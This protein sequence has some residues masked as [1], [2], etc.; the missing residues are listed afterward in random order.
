MYTIIG[1]D[2]KAYGPVSVPQLKQWIAEGRATLDTQAK[3][4]GSEQWQSLRSYPEFAAEAALPPPVQPAGGGV[5]GIGLPMMG[6]PGSRVGAPPEPESVEFTGEWKEYF[7]I[8]IV[9]V[10]LT[11][12]TLGI[13]AAWAKVRKKRYFY[14]NT[15]VFGHTFEYLA[16]PLKIFYGNMIVGGIFLLLNLSVTMPIVYFFLALIFA[17]AVPW[18]IVRGLI[19][20]A[21]NSA[22][23]GLRFN[24]TGTY[25]G[26]FAVYI[27][28]PL[29]VGFTLGLIIPLIEKKKKEFVMNHHT[30]GTTPFGFS[31]M[32]GEIYK[33]FGISFLFFLPLLVAY[34]N[35]TIQL[36]TMRQ[37]G[38][39]FP[40][41]TSI[42]F[43]LG[44]GLIA[45]FGTFYFRAKMFNYVW[46]NTELANNQF[47]ATMEPLKLCGIHL[48]NAVVTL[49]TFGLAHPWA[50]IRV[51]RY[52][53][54]C[55]QI[56]PAGNVDSFVASAQPA[57]GA[58]GDSAGDFFD[59]DIGFG[60]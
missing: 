12:V 43:L 8:W 27:G 37:Q 49:L 7:K 41:I 26:A 53:L 10:L 38:G 16:D 56:I 36:V 19:F 31:G 5:P 15:R 23:R 30:Y 45:F 2:G 20:N 11:I 44:A 33:I 22:W 3:V 54:S 46:D 32:T 28:W 13:Y 59:L 21:R 17:I 4:Y 39:A 35:F 55:L 42:V 47:V 34:I 40:A 1:G 51:M 60:A 9:N 6:S 29:L 58:V 48:L 25:G 52:Q 18:F 24:F 57:V 14:A 50:T